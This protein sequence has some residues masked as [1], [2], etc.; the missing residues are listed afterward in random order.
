VQNAELLRKFLSAQATIVLYIAEIASRA[1]ANMKKSPGL[2]TGAFFLQIL[3]WEKRYLPRLVH[4]N[5][6]IVQLA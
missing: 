6:K 1:N 4:Q 5:D 3:Q 2:L